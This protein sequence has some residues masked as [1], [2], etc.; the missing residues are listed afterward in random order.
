MFEMYLEQNL[1]HSKHSIT[2]IITILERLKEVKM[3][4][5]MCHRELGSKSS[6]LQTACSFIMPYCLLK[7]RRRRN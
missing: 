7:L 5:S 2:I 1:A 3:S 4:Y 6:V